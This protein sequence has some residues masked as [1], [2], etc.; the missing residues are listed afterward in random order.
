MYVEFELTPNLILNKIYL[1]ATH[2]LDSAFAPGGSHTHETAP[3]LTVQVHSSAAFDGFGEYAALHSYVT[4]S[5]EKYGVVAEP[6][7][8][9]AL[10][11]AVSWLSAQAK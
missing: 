1:L 4:V 3:P 8:T 10:A 2:V 5:V 9:A 11:Y 7:F 6:A